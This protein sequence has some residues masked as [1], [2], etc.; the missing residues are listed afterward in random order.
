MQRLK[1]IVRPDGEVFMATVRT[2]KPTKVTKTKG[3]ERFTSKLPDPS[4]LVPGNKPYQLDLGFAHVLTLRDVVF[5][6]VGL[7]NP[8]GRSLL[9]GHKQWEGEE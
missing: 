9:H 2:A 8:R 1:I 6:T 7:V 5:P 4:V 3:P